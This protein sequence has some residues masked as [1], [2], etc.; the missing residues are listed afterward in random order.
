MMVR[1]HRQNIP[2]VER[3]PPNGG[4]AFGRLVLTSLNRHAWTWTFPTNGRHRRTL[5]SWYDLVG[6]ILQ[7]W[8][9][10]LRIAILVLVV[11]TGTA[12]L[13]AK[14]G[15]SGQILIILF[16]VWCCSRRRSC[17]N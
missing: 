4:L 6:R 15:L 3:R 12:E 17:R 1:V 13:A 8:S 7:S 14:I 11:V 5:T 9:L 16:N 10:T 2:E